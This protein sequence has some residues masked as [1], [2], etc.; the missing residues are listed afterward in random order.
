MSKIA[1]LFLSIGNHKS[2]IIWK[3]FFNNIP[4]S[5]YS[6][7][8]HLKTKSTQ[9]FLSSNKIK[10]VIT[11]WGDIS[12]VKATLLL[13][14]NAYQDPSNHFFILV[15][16][17]CIPIISF[18]KLKNRL[19]KINK[20]WIHYRHYSNKYSRYRQLSLN[21]QKKIS[22]GNFY[23]Q[24]QWMCL[25]R[26]D[27]QCILRFPLVNEFSQVKVA[28]EH[29]FIS[30]FYLLNRLNHI[31]N[32][33]ITYCD[34]SENLAHPKEFKYLSDEFLQDII[35]KN[36]LFLRKVSPKCNLT[37]VFKNLKND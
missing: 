17:S 4:Y 21:L 35:E 23:C 26:P 13:L 31:Y 3:H 6:I 8:S 2:E 34:W 29:Y 19:R 16:D 10:G 18:R 22:F 20:S 30:I 9:P 11:N 36:H 32:H 15:S 14:L 27:V 37:N 7:Y 25:V 12:L 24:N 28:D 5:E 33:K 1:F